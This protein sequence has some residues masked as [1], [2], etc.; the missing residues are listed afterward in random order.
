M[1]MRRPWGF[2]RAVVLPDSFTLRYFENIPIGGTVTF[3]VIR[4]DSLFNIN[5]LGY[6]EGPPFED[7][8]PVSGFVLD[9]YGRQAGACEA[10]IEEAALTI[11]PPLVWYEY[12]HWAVPAGAAGSIKQGYRLPDCDRFRF[13]IRNVS[14]GIATAV[15]WY[16]TVRTG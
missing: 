3:P 16:W 15:N 1:S 12:D 2:K 13:S 5:R 7:Y 14:A 4:I 8:I 9:F 10:W 6:D 11:P